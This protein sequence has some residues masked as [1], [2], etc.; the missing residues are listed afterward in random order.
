MNV[1]TLIGHIPEAIEK[2]GTCW[3]DLS[4]VKDAII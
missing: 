3:Q 4:S 1:S 2:I